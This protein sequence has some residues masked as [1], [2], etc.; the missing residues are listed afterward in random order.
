MKLL[1]I[2][3]FCI[4]AGCI[5]SFRICFWGNCCF[6]HWRLTK[7]TSKVLNHFYPSNKTSTSI[8]LGKSDSALIIIISRLK[9]RIVH[10]IGAW[11]K[12][13]GTQK[14]KVPVTKMAAMSLQER[15]VFSLNFSSAGK[16]PFMDSKAE[17][18]YFFKR[19]G[20]GGDSGVRN[21][22][23]PSLRNFLFH[24][25][26]PILRKF[27][28]VIFRQQIKTFDSNNFTMSLMSSFQNACP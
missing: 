24:I 2:L 4:S 18:I 16:G 17:N 27:V 21:V 15:T 19:V 9:I 23:P 3:L 10:F 14:S 13:K 25:L 1:K 5:N 8:Q 11:K 7:I 22:D 20:G 6:K 12:D 28:V 26:R